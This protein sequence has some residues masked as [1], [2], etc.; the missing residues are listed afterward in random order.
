MTSINTIVYI[1]FPEISLK[2]RDAHKL[3]GYFGNIFKEHSELLHNHYAD[4]NYRY[5]YPL[6]Q[7][8]VINR[9][10][11][12]IGLGEGGRLLFDLFLKI[13]QLDVDGVKI[14]VLQKDVEISKYVP[15]IGEALY[16][17]NFETLW[18]G[19]N[20][21]NYEDYQKLEVE[22]EKNKF[23]SKVLQNNILAFMKGINHQ[24]EN[25]IMVTG[26]FNEKM[27]QFKNQSMLAFT[28]TFA[29]NTYLPQYIGLGKSVSR[30]FGTI[31]LTA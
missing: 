29:S 31:Q 10:P 6:V 11:Y 9:M 30:G 20:Q 18:M 19:L 21:H 5:K 17:Y 8:K 13:D 16:Q 22:A 28:G 25:R 12:L 4:G 7:Y 26:K 2:V 23:L 14:P 3:R 27:T 1:K 15:E 24:A